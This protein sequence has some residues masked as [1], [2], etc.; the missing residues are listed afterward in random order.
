MY[1]EYM[2]GAHI[3]VRRYLNSLALQSGFLKVLQVFLEF[4]PKGNGRV[5][6]KFLQDRCAVVVALRIFMHHLQPIICSLLSMHSLGVQPT[7]VILVAKYRSWLCVYF[8]PFP[9]QLG[10]SSYGHRK[11]APEEATAAV[12]LGQ[13]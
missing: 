9:L 2:R 10:Q 7:F 6:G 5:M 8:C 4:V 1:S 13:A 12:R 11:D 3:Q